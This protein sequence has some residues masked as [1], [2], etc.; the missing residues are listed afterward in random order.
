MV[1]SALHIDCAPPR[2]AIANKGHGRERSTGLFHRLTPSDSRQ[3]PQEKSAGT[4]T[5]FAPCRDAPRRPCCSLCSARARS[6]YE[7][8][9]RVR[10]R[11]ELGSVATLLPPAP[12]SLLRNRSDSR[13]QLPT[14]ATPGDRWLGRRIESTHPV[15]RKGLN[16]PAAVASSASEASRGDVLESRSTVCALAEPDRASRL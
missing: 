14:E 16:Y 9:S 7:R 3:A 15:Q 4:N 6:G 10:F 2:L 12:P 5:R 13:R 8:R 11:C 1:F